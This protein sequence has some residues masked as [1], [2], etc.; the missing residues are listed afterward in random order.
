MNGDNQT[1]P[2]ADEARLELVMAASASERANRPRALVVLACIVLAG[3]IGYAVMGISSRSAAA[4]EV[5]SERSESQQVAQMVDRIRAQQA[6]QALRGLEPNSRIGP[7]I[8]ALAE[9]QGLTA[10]PAGKKLVITESEVTGISVPGIVQRKYRAILVGQDPQAILN[11]LNLVQTSEQTRG[12]EISSLNM[13]PEPQ[14]T[15]GA[16]NLDVDFVRW[17][18]K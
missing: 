18:R 13:K 12:V 16:W 6:V 8:E 14:G 2:G 7:E 17:E 11:W 15:R 1:N 9:S 10:D 5:A 4:S 3:A